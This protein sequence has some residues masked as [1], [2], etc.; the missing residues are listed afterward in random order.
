MDSVTALTLF[1]KMR[2]QRNGYECGPVALYNAHV[3]LGM[4]PPSLASLKRDLKTNKHGT[5]E[6]Q[7][8]RFINRMEADTT[9]YTSAFAVER[10]SAVFD[11]L[12]GA[13]LL[14]GYYVGKEGHYVTMLYHVG[15]FYVFNW[16]NDDV[17]EHGSHKDMHKYVHVSFDWVRSKLMAE[18][19]EVYILRKSFKTEKEGQ[20]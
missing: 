15:R 11:L 18:D 6:K 17:I 9:V 13:V 4:K 2:T 20:L 10:R 14:L 16:N 1:D 12:E 8:F 5:S 19:S 3:L 7:M